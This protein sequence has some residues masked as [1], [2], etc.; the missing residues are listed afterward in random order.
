MQLIAIDGVVFSLTTCSEL[1]VLGKATPHSFT[2]QGLG[3]F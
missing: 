3:P 2:S 1:H